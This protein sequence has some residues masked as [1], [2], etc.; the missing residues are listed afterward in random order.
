[1]NEETIESLK[2]SLASFK[3]KYTAAAASAK[4]LQKENLSLSA[5]LKETEKSL[6]WYQEN[7]RTM[8]LENLQLKAMICR[9]EES[10]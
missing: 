2:L 8:N 5:R 10:R 1:M 4:E 6:A 3:G 9:L 7:L